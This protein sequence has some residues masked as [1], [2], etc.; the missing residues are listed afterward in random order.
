MNHNLS[1]TIRS[2]T[3]C[4]AG[5]PGCTRQKMTAQQCLDEKLGY[6]KRL[7]SPWLERMAVPET[8]SAERQTGYRNKVCLSAACDKGPWQV[9]LKR[10]D[11]VL[12][13]HRCAIHGVRVQQA[14]LLFAGILPP[15]DRFPMVFYAQSEAQVTLV[16]KSSRMPDMAWLDLSVKSRLSDMGIEGVWLCLHP[17]AGHRVFAKR[18]WHLVWGN[19]RSKDARGLVYGPATFGQPLVELSEKALDRAEDFLSAGPG[20]RVIDLYC[21]IGAGLARW[22]KKTL[23]VIGV[24]LSS[25][26]VECARQNAPG[27][28]V[29]QGACRQR[30]PQL[31]AA[32]EKEGSRC[33]VYVNPPRTGMEPEVAAWL[34]ATCRPERLACLSCNATALKRDLS[35]LEKAG[36]AVDRLL[37]FDFFPNTRHLETLALLSRG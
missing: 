1:T 12:A 29:L 33:L 3:T 14:L 24:E 10:R 25:E 13:I 21:G 28:T 34:A 22:Q 15:A 9:G 23:R 31:T 35:L 7:L 37:P 4:P 2:E 20:D 32:L 5:C 16:L 26:S 17:C 11:G 19:P 27:A 30:I 8:V 18:G 6:A 36:Y